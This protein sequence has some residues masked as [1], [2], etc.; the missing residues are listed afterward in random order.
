[1]GRKIDL[2][3]KKIGRL[4]VITEAGSDK[5]GHVKWLC[6]CECGTQKV[7]LG[8]PLQ[9]GLT[10]SCGCL[11]K[12]AVSKATSTHGMSGTTTY[13]AW[14]SMLGRCIYP[15]T[16]GYKNYGGRGITVCERWLHSFENFYADMGVKPKKLT[17]ERIDN[18]KGYSPDNCKWASR[19]ENNRNKRTNRIIRYD[20]KSQCISAWEEDLGMGKG[21][22]SHRLRLYPPQIAI[23]M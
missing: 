2:T 4:T 7:I 11:R 1:M 12:E 16:N 13:S 10:R 22:L 18:N 6:Q 14:N 8:D 17:L 5:H 15:N 23:N 19:T 20:G 9:R 3:G 21:V